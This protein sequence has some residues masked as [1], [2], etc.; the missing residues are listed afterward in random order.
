M[1]NTDLKTHT[2]FMSVYKLELKII[3]PYNN[4]HKHSLI[5][6]YIKCWFILKGYLTLWLYFHMH[7]QFLS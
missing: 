6:N 2:H 4:M 3:S 1:N 7:S 5:S